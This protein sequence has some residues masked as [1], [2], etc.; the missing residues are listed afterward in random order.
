MSF[1]SFPHLVGLLAAC[2]CVSNSIV[3]YDVTCFFSSVVA[4]PKDSLDN[5][6]DCISIEE[7]CI[8]SLTRS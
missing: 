2:R 8:T 1:G 4:F 5:G 3:D 7:T 6:D